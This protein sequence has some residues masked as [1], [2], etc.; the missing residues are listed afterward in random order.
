LNKNKDKFEY[1]YVE[2]DGTVREL[3]NQEIEYLQTEFKPG[4]GARPY[5]KSNY[6]QLAPDKKIS[7]FLHRSKVPE[8]IEIIKTD[9]RYAEFGFPINICDSNKVIELHVGIF[10]VY[11]FGGWDVVVEDFTF[12]LTNIKNGRIINPRDTQWRIQSYECGHLAKKIKVLDIPER[13]N[14]L[15]DF[16]NLDSLKV[17]NARLPLVFRIFKK[18]IE[19]QNIAISI[20]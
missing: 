1:V 16:K 17:W 9:I 3:D 4:D 14:Y 11:V 12:T 6:E 15:I 10:S 7:G 19:K 18:P 2:K 5:I 13:G 20:V 8:N